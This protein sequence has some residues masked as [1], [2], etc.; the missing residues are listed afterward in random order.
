M[1]IIW[2]PSSVMMACGG[3][4]ASSPAAEMKRTVNES[5]YT[6]AVATA[7]RRGAIAG[8]ATQ[9]FQIIVSLRPLSVG[10]LMI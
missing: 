4:S 9:F 2:L 10:T 3:L 6:R 8:R 7:L 1:R 5:P